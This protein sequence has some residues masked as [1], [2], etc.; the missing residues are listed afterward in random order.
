MSKKVILIVVA[1]IAIVG[2]VIIFPKFSLFMA[3][4]KTTVNNKAVEFYIK[5]FTSL[6]V[7]AQDL[8]KQGAI[9]DVKA[10]I[11]VAEYKGLG[12]EN[13]APGKYIVNK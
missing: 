10:F 1:V 4:R 11:G 7:L 6:E 9:D 5:G 3:S 2:G 13:I 12:K 8:E